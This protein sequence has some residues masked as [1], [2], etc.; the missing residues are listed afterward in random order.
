MEDGSFPSFALPTNGIHRKFT[1]EKIRKN[2]HAYWLSVV[3][4]PGG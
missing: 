3:T 4:R 2:V 1:N